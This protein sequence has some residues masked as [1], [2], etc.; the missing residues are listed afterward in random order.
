MLSV[1]DNLFKQLSKYKISSLFLVF[2]A[3]KIP[4]IFTA[5]IA[6]SNNCDKGATAL[7]VTISYFS[8]FSIE[9]ISALSFTTSIPSRL[10]FSI[11]SFKNVH[12]FFKESTKVTFKL[13]K[14]IFKG[15]PGKPAPVP[16]SHNFWLSK[17]HILAIVKES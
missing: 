4:L 8:T 2:I 1:N 3:I 16:I 14:T 10:S 17:L 7:A 5:H 6:I 12:L 13:G 9:N 15:I 11:T